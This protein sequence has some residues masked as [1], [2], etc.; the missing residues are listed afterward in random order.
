MLHMLQAVGAASRKQQGDEPAE[1]EVLPAGKRSTEAVKAS[2]AL[3]DAL[4]LAAHE[5]ERVQV[6]L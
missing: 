6:S 3:M 5:A 1:G 2:D 4:E